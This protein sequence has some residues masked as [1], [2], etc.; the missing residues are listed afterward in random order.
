MTNHHQISDAI[1]EIAKHKNQIIK[2]VNDAWLLCDFSLSEPEI[3]K[4]FVMEK[5]K[6]IDFL[7][8]NVA[9]LINGAQSRF[10]IKFGG[11][12]A[13]QRPYIKRSSRNCLKK[14]G[15]NATETCELADLLCLHVFVD[16]AKNVITSQASFFQ[17]KKSEAID[18][19]TQ[20]WF[21]D[22]D[23]EFSYKASAFWEKTSAGNASRVMPSW[24]EHRSSAFQYLLLLSGNP[25]VRLSPWNVEHKHKFGFFLYK[26]ITF[27]TGKTYDYKD[28]LAGGW[29]SIVN[30]VL[31]MGSRTM[32]GKPRNSPGLDEVIDYFNDFRDHDKQVMDVNGP[33][34]TILLSIVQDTDRQ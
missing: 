13:H 15:T 25:T 8:K 4:S 18:N 9:T 19:Q 5:G 32:K 26:L 34:V 28:R 23:N 11:V 7:N 16:S 2:S 22:L 24:G 17:A 30:D 20:R 33:G 3:I 27:S 10:V 6:G 14:K 1:E 31:Q 21:Y 12:F 29:S